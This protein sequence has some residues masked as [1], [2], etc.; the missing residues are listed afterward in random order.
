MMLENDIRRQPAA[1]QA[2]AAAGPAGWELGLK[3]LGSLTDYGRL[4]F[5]GMGNSYFAAV[6]AAYDCVLRGIPAAVE[7]ASS[8]LYYG[9]GRLRPGDLLVAISQSGES[10]EVVRLLAHLDG[11]GP[12]V[13]GVTNVAGSTLAQQARAVL[14][15]GV[16]PDHGVAIKTYGASLL[17]L[18]YLNGR[19]A[20][21]PV[22][23]WADAVRAAA[24]AVAA[25][26]GQGKAWR[27]LGRSLAGQ[28]T[29][30]V[31]NGQ[32][33]SLSSAMAGA[34][35]CNEVAKV[36][37]WAEEAGEFRHGIVEVAEPG[38]LAAV[39]LANGPTRD[40]GVALA[41]ELAATGARAMAVAPP[42]CGARLAGMGAEVLTVPDLGESLMPLVQ[43][44]PFQWLSL[45]WA[46]GR[47][48]VPGRFR[49]MAGTVGSG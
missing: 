21:Q 33:P 24:A 27:A 15:T 39:V 25:A 41:A 20:G 8:L 34:L 44:V 45:G 16:E 13:L 1:F 37:A 11:T 7:L 23:A 26:N 6:A 12:A 5:T 35:L 36:P 9:G 42:S 30:A 29:A 19:L 38:V 47:G 2:L 48:L 28:I 49:H 4:V 22:A 17:A 31:I 14:V 18:L 43:V 32:G 3:R 40:L 10:V 46:E